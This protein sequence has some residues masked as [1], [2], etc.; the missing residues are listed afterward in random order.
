[1]ATKKTF[2]KSRQS[3]KVD[4]VI[5]AEFAPEA[6]EIRL[7]GDF[8]NWEWKSAPVLKNTK[9]QYKIKFE[10]PAGKKYEYRFLADEKLWLNDDN[11]DA[12]VPSPHFVDNCIVDLTV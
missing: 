2:V 5:P 1:M 7:V 9:G 6:K 10:L 3:Y 12:Y 4:F 8:N 11:A